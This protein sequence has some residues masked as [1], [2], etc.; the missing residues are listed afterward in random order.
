MLSRFPFRTL[1]IAPIAMTLLVTGAAYIMGKSVANHEASGAAS[2]AVVFVIAG[3]WLSG[4]AL[5]IADRVAMKQYETRHEL[6]NSI[7]PRM[8]YHEFHAETFAEP[9]RVELSP[10]SAVYVHLPAHVT[11]DQLKVLAFGV[12]RASKP[13]TVREWSGGGRLFSKQHYKDLIEVMHSTQLIQ[14]RNANRAGGVEL[15]DLGRQ[16]LLQ[17]LPPS[18]RATLTLLKP[19]E[20]RPHMNGMHKE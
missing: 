1:I 6:A 19:G 2:A 14:Q 8:E 10:T 9:V 20:R 3:T 18:A 7:T 11:H 5:N 17:F 4:L 15:T 12:M 16:F 13:F